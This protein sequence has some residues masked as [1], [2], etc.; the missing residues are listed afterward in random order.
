MIAGLIAGVMLT[1][2]PTASAAPA[3]SGAV[4]V[5]SPQYVSSVSCASPTWCVAVNGAGEATTFN[6]SGWTG[7]TVVDGVG[8]LTSVSCVSHSFCVAVDLTGHAITFNGSKWSAP[9]QI[10]TFAEFLEPVVSCVSQTFCVAVNHSH[11]AITFNG[12]SWSSPQPIDSLTNS[13][14][15]VSCASQSFCVAV[16]RGGRVMTFNGSGWS[17]PSEIDKFGLASVSCASSTFCVAADVLG[18]AAIYNGTNWSTAAAA[19]AGGAEIGSVS[20]AS[21][22]FCVA[23]DGNGKANVFDGSKWSVQASL[24]SAEADLAVSCATTSFCVAVDSVGEAFSYAEGNAPSTH[25]ESPTNPGTSPLS[26]HPPVVPRPPTQRLCAAAGKFSVAKPKGYLVTRREGKCIEV[27]LPADGIV[28]CERPPPPVGFV[29]LETT[30]FDRCGPHNT[31]AGGNGYRMRRPG[32]ETDM[33]DGRVP[34]GYVVTRVMILRKCGP[35]YANRPYNAYQI[36]HPLDGIVMCRTTNVPPGFVVT[37]EFAFDESFDHIG[38]CGPVYGDRPPDATAFRIEHPHNDIVMCRA[39]NV[40][41]GYVV[42]VAY[43]FGRPL[44]FGRCG[45]VFGDNPP[46]SNAY[47][48]ELPRD[49]LVMCAGGLPAGYVI[50]EIFN[51]EHPLL[52]GTCGPTPYSTWTIAHP[53]KNMIICAI[54]APSGFIVT[55]RMVTSQCGRKPGYT[56]YNASKIVPVH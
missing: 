28:V 30:D 54:S 13:P 26:P 1:V 12:S 21:A 46:S 4:P 16:D 25:A 6:G 38:R 42:T 27:S 11:D 36:E 31:F 20:C 50:T 39:T 33:C 32:S 40:P 43:A 34:A 49:G 55:E 51:D 9:M 41:K 7:A 35:T 37:E 23:V 18:N 52:F 29:V 10:D 44:V 2:T 17:A 22:S 24:A 14:E 56:K 48:I 8:G 47:R 53:V 3:W 5:M 45:R 15:S 19:A